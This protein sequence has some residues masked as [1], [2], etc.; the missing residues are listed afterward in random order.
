MGR[1]LR[2]DRCGCCIELGHGDRWRRRRREDLDPTFAV[3]SISH[4]SGFLLCT[5]PS[6][7]SSHCKFIFATLFR[8]YRSNS[9]GLRHSISL[10]LCITFIF[11]SIIMFGMVVVLLLL[12]LNL[13]LLGSKLDRNASLC[14]NTGRNNMDATRHAC[15]IR[16][17]STSWTQVENPSTR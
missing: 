13:F 5:H 4:T 12:L 7:D 15:D 11:I 9:E 6:C 3:H 1:S 8:V 16:A 14:R 17:T 2:L 10:S